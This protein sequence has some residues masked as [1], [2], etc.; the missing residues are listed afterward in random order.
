MRAVWLSY[1]ELNR[2]LAADTVEAVQAALDEV[3]DNCVS[4]GVNTVV[5]HVRANSDAYYASALFPPARRRSRGWTRALIRWRM[6]CRRRT[7]AGWSCMPGSIL[8]VWESKEENKR[9][10]DVFSKVVGDAPMWYYV[11]SSAPVQK[12]I[13][14]GIRELL[15]Y[16]IDGVQFDDYF[17]PTGLMS[18]L[19]EAFETEC[20]ASDAQGVAEWAPLPG[21]RAGRL[22]PR[23]GASE[24]WLCVWDQ[25]VA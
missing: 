5:F 12:L 9:C 3:M 14:D 23:R 4:Y 1:V 10:D 17:Y 22:G 16:D 15:R 18:P 13:L 11:P 24:G 25:P 8:T 6:R 2:L 7:A 19:T 20:P 21:G